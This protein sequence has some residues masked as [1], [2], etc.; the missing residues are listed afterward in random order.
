MKQA[1]LN[2]HQQRLMQAS[3]GHADFSPHPS[4][5]SRIDFQLE[6]RLHPDS[7]ASPSHDWFQLDLEP[8]LLFYNPI[9]QFIFVKK[10]H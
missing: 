9:L 10:K 1:M 2:D 7:S 6:R 8:N 3:L 5:S 4:V